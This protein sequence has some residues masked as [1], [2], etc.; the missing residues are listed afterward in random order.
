MNEIIVSIISISIIF[1]GTILGS[2]LVFFIRTSKFSDRVSNMILGFASGVMFAA[3]IFGLLLPSISQSENNEIYNNWSFVPPIV[4]FILGCI[5]LYILDK[6]IP[7]F[8]KSDN[9]EEGIRTDKLTKN[10]KFFLA[11]TIHNIP[12]GLAVGFAAGLAIYTKSEEAIFSCLSLAI[13]IALQNIPEGTAISIPYYGE[14]YSKWKSFFL[15]SLTGI[16][17]PVFAIIGLFMAAYLTSTMPW[18][19]SFAAGAMIYVTVDELLPEARRGNYI[20]YGI[21]AFIIGFIIMTALEIIL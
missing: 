1:L 3:A 2:S 11:V 17:E 4:G 16:V 13:G 14:G 21:W 15:G 9:N 12:E 8:H 18:L 7:H 19:L 10:T 6:V 5:F 20:H